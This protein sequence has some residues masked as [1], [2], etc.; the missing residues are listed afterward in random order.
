[1][2]LDKKWAYLL[3]ED[4]K[5]NKT[6][7]GLLIQCQTTGCLLALACQDL[8]LIYWPGTAPP[9]YLLRPASSQLYTYVSFLSFY[10]SLTLSL[11]LKLSIIF[12]ATDLSLL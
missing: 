6:R 3:L 12:L 5:Q 11:D 1:M 10:L 2:A 9:S 4:P 7:S 8:V